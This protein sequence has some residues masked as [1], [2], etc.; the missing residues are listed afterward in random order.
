M[1]PIRV[2]LS[3]FIC[4]SYFCERSIVHKSWAIETK[5]RSGSWRFF[6]EI[7]CYAGAQ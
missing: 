4:G 6:N 7:P 1:T 2:K 3:D 5:K